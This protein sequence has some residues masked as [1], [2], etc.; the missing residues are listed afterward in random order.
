MLLWKAEVS[1]WRRGDPCST[2]RT[3]IHV[4]LRKTANYYLWTATISSPVL[5]KHITM[6]CLCHKVE[7]IRVVMRN[8]HITHA[9]SVFIHISQNVKTVAGGSRHIFQTSLCPPQRPMPRFIS[10]S[11]YFV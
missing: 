5:I 11:L 6:S 10:F 4:T 8:L 1:G 7:T 3:H 9:V 2:L